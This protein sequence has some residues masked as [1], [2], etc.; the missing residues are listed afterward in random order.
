V[1]VGLPGT[2]LLGRYRVIRPIAR[3]AVATVYLAFDLHGTPYAL[4]VFP[5]GL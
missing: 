5:K 4:K 1:I 3:G 2:T